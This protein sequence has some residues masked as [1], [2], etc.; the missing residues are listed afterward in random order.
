MSIGLVGVLLSLVLGI[1][2]GGLSGYYGGIL[3]DLIQRVIEFLRS[4][5]SIPLWMALSAALPA[6]WPALRVYFGI[7]VILSL[8][9]WTWLARGGCAGAFSRCVRRIS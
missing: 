1:L 8:I 9:S 2:I 7:T 5:P 4:M 3:D 6:Q